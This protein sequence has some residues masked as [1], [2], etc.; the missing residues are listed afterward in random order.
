MSEVCKECMHFSN[1][2]SE[3]WCNKWEDDCN[4]IKKPSECFDLEPWLAK[5]KYESLGEQ[6]QVTKEREEKLEKENA[7]LREALELYSDVKTWRKQNQQNF[8]TASIDDVG[9]MPSGFLCGGER[10]RQTLKEIDGE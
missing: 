4:E 8:T 7:K 2:E 1:F 5:E 6:L 10:A 9:R 3:Q